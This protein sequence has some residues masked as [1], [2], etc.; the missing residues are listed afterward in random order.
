MKRIQLSEGLTEKSCRERLREDIF[1]AADF[2]TVSTYRPV[3][4]AA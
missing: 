1:E 2:G 4:V 3:S